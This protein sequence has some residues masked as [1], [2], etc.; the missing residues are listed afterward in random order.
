MARIQRFANIRRATRDPISMYSSSFYSRPF[1]W[2]AARIVVL[3]VAIV[4]CA[5]AVTQTAIVQGTVRDSNEKTVASAKVV[6]QGAAGA[7][8]AAA[9]TDALGAYKL[10]GVAS[11]AYTVQVEASGYTR[12][13]FP[14]FKLKANDVKVLDL[15]L[16]SN[17]PNAQAPEFYDEPQ[18]TVAGVTDTTNLG[19]HGADTVVRNT[20]SLVRETA[21][22]NHAAAGP[23]APPDAATL[24]SLRGAVQREP[25]SFQANHQLGKSLLDS[26]NARDAVP[27]LER[28]AALN[29]V[30]HQAAYDLASA[31]A[32][33][34]D[35]NHAKSVLQSSAGAPESAD[36]HRLLGD[37]EENLGD[38]VEAVHEYQRAAE[39][40]PTESNLFTWGAE[41]LQHRAFEPASE[42]FKKGSRLY[43]SSARMLVGLG[44]S[45]Y[46]RGSYEP[47]VQRL[48]QAAD[49]DPNATTPYLFLGKIQTIDPA[50]SQEVSERLERFAR[51][52]P[53]NTLASYYYAMSLWKTRRG[54]EDTAN[55]A[56]IESLLN[57]SVKR[58]P[59]L[60]DAYLQ[61]GILYEEQ[62]NFPGAL[63]AYKQAVE[64]SPQ[65]EQAHYRLAQAFRKS[66][67]EEKAKGEMMLYQ[68]TSKQS[69]DRAQRE[70]REMQGFVY[71]MRD[72][73]FGT[74][75]AQKSPAPQ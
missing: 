24:R 75:A 34:G 46:A 55:L 32:A 61:L 48:C 6:L 70:Q 38:P 18:F 58:D 39:L 72:Q 54:P 15:V 10:P 62:R 1:S 5:P 44:V 69:A 53:E 12:Q 7:T 41:L 56:K 71:T 22:M 74:P 13:V 36:N 63:S 45:L 3:S 50:H 8:V 25:R 66:G 64:V 16:T 28:A 4:C 20:E 68:E 9:K 37:V 43:P 57:E 31:C 27:Y 30:D 29:P 59:K 35:Y 40:E 14:Q 19:T 52:Q 23:A 67:D 33:V 42:V 65:L 51:L 49:L 47:A 73:T 11:G 26:G 17:G 2:I 21:S 60:G